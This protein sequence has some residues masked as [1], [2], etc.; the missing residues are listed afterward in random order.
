MFDDDVEDSYHE[1]YDEGQG[2]TGFFSGMNHSALKRQVAY[3]KGLK[4]GRKDLEHL[5]DLEIDEPD[6][7]DSDE[8]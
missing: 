3:K 7:T 8:D 2:K 1:G 5:V 6:S 4:D